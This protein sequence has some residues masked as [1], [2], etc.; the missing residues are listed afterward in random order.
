MGKSVA[1]IRQQILAEVER[2][3]LQQKQK[4]APKAP[5][6]L[7]SARQVKNDSAPDLFGREKQPATPRL[8]P[9]GPVTP[10]GRQETQQPLVARPAGLAP[11]LSR[12]STP[13]RRA[14]DSWWSAASL[15]DLQSSKKGPGEVPES[16]LASPR[17]R[18]EFREAMVG[19]SQSLN[20]I[21]AES[22]ALLSSSFRSQE[23]CRYHSGDGRIRG[24]ARVATKENQSNYM[25]R[26]E[27][28][29]FRA[30]VTERLMRSSNQKRT[31][32]QVPAAGMSTSHDRRFDTPAGEAALM[33]RARSQTPD[34]HRRYAHGAVGTSLPGCSQ[35]S[36][37][38]AGYR[39]VERPSTPLSARPSKRVLSGQTS[40]AAAATKS[41]E[42]CH[43]YKDKEEGKHL[44]RMIVSNQAY[45][46]SSTSSHKNDSAG[47]VRSRCHQ[48]HASTR[49]PIGDS[50][51]FKNKLS[52]LSADG[53]PVW[54]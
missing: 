35:N 27:C 47:E 51:K 7:F 36:Q 44:A 23:A 19:H 30:P 48:P 9:R 33:G 16:P 39:S 6:R 32:A 52:Q 28:R 10:R 3:V 2:E 46:M 17:S 22:G 1:E 18:K 11:G 50:A 40:S 21:G 45:N 4:Q 38:A 20:N 13:S 15:A 14:R 25:A 12:E 37:P 29:F 42:A 5:V 24:Q 43:F 41:R 34:Y 26:E 53:R 8:S 31:E 49:R 54:N